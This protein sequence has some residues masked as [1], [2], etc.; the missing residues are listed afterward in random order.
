MTTVNLDQESTTR[1]KEMKVS[2]SGHV[3]LVIDSLRKYS[4]FFA[5][6]LAFGRTLSD[7]IQ[8]WSPHLFLDQEPVC[9]GPHSI[10]AR[11]PD[12]AQQ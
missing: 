2:T 5:A 10:I 7:A 9:F 1:Y 12:E 6:C 11:K 8:D 3:W 4:K